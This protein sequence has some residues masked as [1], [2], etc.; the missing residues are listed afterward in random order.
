VIEEPDLR[1]ILLFLEGDSVAVSDL[2]GGVIRVF[3]E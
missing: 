2:E 3:S 1:L